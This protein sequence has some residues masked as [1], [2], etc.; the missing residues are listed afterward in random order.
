MSILLLLLVF[1]IFASDSIP[2]SGLCSQDPPSCDDFV[3]FRKIQ[4]LILLS[5]TG[6]HDSLHVKSSV[7]ST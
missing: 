1:I 3:V 6:D 7:K 5:F 4:S 2:V